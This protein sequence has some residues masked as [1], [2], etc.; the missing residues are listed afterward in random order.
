[1]KQS[2]IDQLIHEYE[3]F[4]MK[5]DDKVEDMFERFSKIVNNLG[6]LGKEISEG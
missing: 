6:S 5:E 3:L 1:M 2:K 4:H